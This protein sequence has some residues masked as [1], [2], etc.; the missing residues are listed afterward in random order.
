[1]FSAG[2]PLLA[3]DV[4]MQS[5]LDARFALSMVSLVA[6]V[7]TVVACSSTTT[8]AADN[9]PPLST[10]KDGGTSSKGASSS[11]SSSGAAGT[12]DTDASATDTDGG[13]EDCSKTTDSDSC[14]MCCY[15]IDPTDIDTA[16]KAYTDCQCATTTCATD[17]AASFCGS[18]PNATP[19]AACTTCLNKNDAACE[20]QFDAAC[21]SA[22]CKAATQ[23]QQT[24]CAK[25][26]Q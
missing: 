7:A 18:D 11:S 1:M 25:Y 21:T 14:E 22:G 20:M 9:D 17:C 12:D 8:S 10:T 26:S 5:R 3:R 24:N 6:A 4:V 15:N 23:C 16:E 19:T 13:T 2:G